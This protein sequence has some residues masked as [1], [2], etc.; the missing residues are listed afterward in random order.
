VIVRRRAPAWVIGVAGLAIAAAVAIR[1]LI[2]A[3]MDASTFLGLGDDSPIQT[4]Y[5]R[6]RL[7]E[8]P[9]RAGMGHDGKFFFVQANDPWYLDPT[10]HAAVIDRPLYRGQRMLY[11]MIAGGFGSFPPAVIVWSM[12]ATNLIAIAFGSWLG[13]KLAARWGGSSWI[14]LA[15]PLNVGL[16]FEVLIDGAGVIAY[17]FCLGA[18]Y[19][20]E[21]DRRWTASFLFAAAALSR[22][23]M[24]LFAIGVLIGGWLAER[25]LQWRIVIAPALTMVTWSVYLR[26]RLAGVTGVGGGTE[27]FAPPF[28][29]M[30]QAIRSWATHPDDLLLSA[31]IL[32][33]VVSFTLLAVRSR[34]SI[35]W[36][37]LPFVALATVLSINVWRE[38]FDLSRVL[39]PVFTAAPYILFLSERGM[40]S[41][42]AEQPSSGLHP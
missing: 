19:A 36:G 16:I 40:T 12:L 2:P 24:I 35:A 10:R 20:L 7:G 15:I 26:W 18:L 14:G 41:P 27:N 4:E 30:W 9:T 22:E 37:A 17:V 25:R 33:A 42:A 5:A 29:G 31:A 32:V 23:V 38:P 21:T 11:P 34:L 1:L 6:E 3:G 8:V 13:A 39:A 28:A